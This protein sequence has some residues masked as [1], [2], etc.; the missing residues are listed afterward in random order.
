[1]ITIRY[2]ADTKAVTFSQ[3]TKAISTLPKDLAGKK[4]KRKLWCNPLLHVFR[5]RFA[6]AGIS[7]EEYYKQHADLLSG[8]LKSP[9]EF[10]HSVQTVGVE[11]NPVCSVL[12][13]LVSQQVVQFV[14][15]ATGYER[16]RELC[17]YDSARELSMSLSTG[18]LV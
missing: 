2:R 1:M 4:K 3:Y 11:F 14:A 6:C 15:G 12:G 7:A 18:D 16:M 13:A 5:H 17:V 9:A 10:T 8:Q